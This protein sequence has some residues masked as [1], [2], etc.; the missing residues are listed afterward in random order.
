MD[1][2]SNVTFHITKCNQCGYVTFTSANVSNSP[3]SGY[4]NGAGSLALLSSS[5]SRSSA[6]ATPTQ[7]PSATG[8]YLPTTLSTNKLPSHTIQSPRTTSSS[9]PTNS[10]IAPGNDTVDLGSSSH[11]HVPIGAGVGV[12]IGASLV[13]L[14]LAF[15]F[16]RCSRTRKACGTIGADVM[17]SRPLNMDE[18]KDGKTGMEKGKAANMESAAKSIQSKPLPVYTGNEDNLGDYLKQN[19]AGEKSET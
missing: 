18:S 5:A 8:V 11:S 12:S 6:V 3:D 4:C 15:L 19:V 13:I 9:I 2:N 16:L 14:T 10:I 1:E 7:A 17:I